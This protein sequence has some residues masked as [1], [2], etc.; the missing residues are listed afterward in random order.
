MLCLG[1]MA[2]NRGWK[3]GRSRRGLR[4]PTTTTLFNGQWVVSSSEQEQEVYEG[5]KELE[6]LFE[7]EIARPFS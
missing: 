4:E 5:K 7:K 3:G 2:H 6:K 1:V